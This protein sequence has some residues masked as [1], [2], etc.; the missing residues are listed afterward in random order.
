LVPQFPFERHVL[1]DEHPLFVPQETLSDLPPMTQLLQA[2]GA[3]V[4]HP[5]IRPAMAATMM[6]VFAR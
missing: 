3:G 2:L 4:A 5:L 6:T 1:L